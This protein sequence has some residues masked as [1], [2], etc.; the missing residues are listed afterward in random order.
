ML[1]YLED[2]KEY[3]ALFFMPSEKIGA[4]QISTN[5]Y[6]NPGEPLE[7]NNMGFS[8]HVIL[9]KEG[10]EG[11]ENLDHFDAIL[12]EPREYISNLITQDWYG[13][14]AKK[15]TTSHAFLNDVLAK[16]RNYC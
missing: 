15:T 10:E 8:W 3:D 5:T 7:N 1:N 11:I 9:F 4:I 2:I 6:K 13:V 16:F 14:I 12:S